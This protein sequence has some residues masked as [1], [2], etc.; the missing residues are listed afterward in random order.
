MAELEV[1]DAFLML[2]KAPDFQGLLLW[3]EKRCQEP[4]ID[5]PGESW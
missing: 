5:V 2:E 4:F 1:H 3:G